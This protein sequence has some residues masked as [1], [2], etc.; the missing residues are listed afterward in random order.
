MVWYLVKK[1]LIEI[2]YYFFTKSVCLNK[3]QN[4]GL[5][6]SYWFS[7]L[8]LVKVQIN[9]TAV[10]LTKKN[11]LLIVQFKKILCVFGL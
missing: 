9:K 7:L 6:T 5:I 2:Y 11:V 10:L 4:V 1:K 8:K 3:I